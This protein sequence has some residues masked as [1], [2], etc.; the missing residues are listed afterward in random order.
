MPEVWFTSDTHY[1]HANVIEYSKRPY[2][3]VEEMDEALVMNWNNVVRPGDQVYHL[4]DFAFCDEGRATRIAKR[5]M[6]QKFL[7]FGNH[8]KRLRRCKEF[9]SQWIWARDLEGITVHGQRIVLCHYAMHVWNQSHRGAWQLHGHSHGSLPVDPTKLRMDVGV[10][11]NGYYPLS[12]GGVAAEM[13]KREYEPVD[14]HGKRE[15][16]E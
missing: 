6:G 10:D 9:L 14:H 13:K 11:P 16:D 8:D 12:F 3:D 7:V 5:L 4:G 1:G 15:Q 2:A